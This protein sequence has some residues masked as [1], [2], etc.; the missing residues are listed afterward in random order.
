MQQWD[1]VEIVKHVNLDKWPMNIDELR[2]FKV[3]SR[4]TVLHPTAGFD[5]GPTIIGPTGV[6]PF[7][8]SEVRLV[9]V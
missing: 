9:D 8:P 2:F 7:H 3:G 6:T 1:T 4:H 5:G